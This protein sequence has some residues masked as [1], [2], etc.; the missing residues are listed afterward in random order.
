MRRNEVFVLLLLFVAALSEW[1]LVLSFPPDYGTFLVLPII[2]CLGMGML[3]C[4]VL[5]SNQSRRLTE[6]PSGVSWLIAG[7]IL[8]GSIAMDLYFLGWAVSSI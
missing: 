7:M 1:P 5:L 3:A 4:L 2:K 8:I 6:P